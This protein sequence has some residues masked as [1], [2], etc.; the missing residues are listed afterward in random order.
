MSDHAV[1]P[2]G[3]HP[4]G[5]GP[6]AH[7]HQ[8]DDMEQQ[9][10]AGSLG[11]WLFLITEIMFFGGMFTGYAV[12]REK[13]YNAFVQGSHHLGA[14]GAGKGNAILHLAEIPLPLR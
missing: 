5:H 7:A 1:Q 13:Y 9:R 6:A 8:F 11:M 2:A 14:I 4:A 10:E 12:Y 3:Y